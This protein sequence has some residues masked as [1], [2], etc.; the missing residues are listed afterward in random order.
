[1]IEEIFLRLLFGGAVGFAIGLTSIGGAVFMLPLLTL[2]LGFTSS[3]AVGTASLYS[4]AAKVFA[5]PRHIALNNVDFAVAKRFL[6]GA[7]PGNLVVTIAINRYMAVHEQNEQLTDA[8]QQ[9]LRLSIIAVI[10]LAVILMTINLIRRSRRTQGEEPAPVQPGGGSLFASIVLSIVVGAVVGATAISAVVV[11]PL[12]ILHFKLPARYTVGTTVFTT[13]VLMLLTSVVYLFGKQ[14]DV[15]TALWM[16][17]G[18]VVGVYFGS[19]LT[20]RLPEQQLRIAVITL[21]ALAAAMML[22][23]SGK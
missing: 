9:Q 23:F 8:F 19:R 1:V 17:L 22:I 21:V 13:L 6:I 16:A 12:M 3:E 10:F 4:F 7:V 15:R 14:I 18:S 5:G 2:W 11:V 20:G